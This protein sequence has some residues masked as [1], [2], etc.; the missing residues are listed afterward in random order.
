MVAVR[1]KIN[2][3]RAKQDEELEKRK[4]LAQL[5]GKVGSSR[6]AVFLDWSVPYYLLKLV[7]MYKIY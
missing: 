6:S 5:K 7:Y 2:R 4:R 3:E 1:S